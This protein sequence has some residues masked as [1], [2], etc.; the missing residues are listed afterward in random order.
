M[1]TMQ[2]DAA[3]SAL[4]AMQELFGAPPESVPSVACLLEVQTSSAALQAAAALRVET[5]RLKTSI[6]KL[7]AAEKASCEFQRA[8][9]QLLARACT[10]LCHAVV[11]PSEPSRGERAE[12][13]AAEGLRKEVLALCDAVRREIELAR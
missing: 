4:S 6:A 8:Q 7:R 3:L 9:M 5:A 1:S 12:A 10:Q 13:R 11:Q 2:R